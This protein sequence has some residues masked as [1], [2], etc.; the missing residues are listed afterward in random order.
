MPFKDKE[1]R[2]T[3]AREWIA[4]R[5]KSYL[6][7]LGPCKNC[8]TTEDLQ[9]DHKDRTTKVSHRIWSWA[10][11]RLDAEL[12]KCQIFC[13]DCH[14]KKSF[15][16]SEG[17]YDFS[18]TL[19]QKARQLHAEGLSTRAIAKELNL[20]RST[21]WRLVTQDSPSCAFGDAA[22]LSMG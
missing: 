6:E 14:R 3:Y 13:G 20:P 11:V 1:A 16:H 21:A 4:A 7:K 12:A 9:V 15:I 17:Q 5:R 2:R 8:G 22:P 19:I 10:T 18:P